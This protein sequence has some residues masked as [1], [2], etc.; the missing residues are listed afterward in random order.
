MADVN[1]TSLVDVAFVLLIIFMIT[2]PMMNTGVDIDLPAVTAQ[3]I[4]DPEGKL[5][6]SIAPNRAIKLGGT[7][8]KWA[9][10]EAKLKS[11]ERVQRESQIYIEADKDLPYAV[12]ITA[13]AIAKNANVSKVMMLTEPTDTLM[14]SDLDTGAAQNKKP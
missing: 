11:N 6:M 5:V 8:V 12:V 2:A 4:E 7:D 3:N 13:M 9:D 1:V 10:L 14:L